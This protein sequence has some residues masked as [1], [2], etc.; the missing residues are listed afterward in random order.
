MRPFILLSECNNYVEGNAVACAV[1][2]S[3]IYA[4][5]NSTNGKTREVFVADG[6][7]EGLVI[8]TPM[9]VQEILDRIEAAVGE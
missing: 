5:G 3:L 4:I 2:A 9:Q 1:D 8:E 7:T 6:T